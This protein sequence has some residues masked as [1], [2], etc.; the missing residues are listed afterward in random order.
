LDIKPEGKI[1]N[2][3]DLE[4]ILSALKADNKK[5]V[6]C[7]GVFDLVH[8][9]HIRYFNLAKKE[10]DILVVTLTSDKYVKRGPGRPIFN[11]NLRAEMLASI[12]IIDYVAIIDFPASIEAIKILKPNF[13]VKGSDYKDE[14][15]DV[16]GM[17][18]YE[19]EAVSS[20]G[21]KL[22]FT[23][24]ITFSS[25][26]LINNFLD[27][28]PQEI[29][30]YLKK[31]KE[32]Y[33]I[34]D[35]FDKINS[36]KKLKVLVIGDSIIDQY[37]YCTPLGKSSKEHLVANL[38]DSEETFAGGSL[39]TA[40]HIS[41]ICQKVDLLTVLGGKN[42]YKDFISEKLNSNIDL[43]YFIWPDTGTVVKRRFV[44]KAINTK[45]F[46]I[47]YLKREDIPEIVEEKILNHLDRTIKNYDLIVANDFG[48]G[49]LTKN[50]INLICEKSSYL[51]L[52]VQT[53]SANIG[54][55]MVTKYPRANFVCIDDLELRLATHDRVSDLKILAKEIFNLLNCDYIIATRGSYGSIGYST[56]EG[57]NE[58]PAFS[59][60][61]VDAIGAG[62]AFFSY[63]SPCIAGGFNL[64][65]TSFIGNAAGSLATQIICNREPV[66]YA[67]LMK[68]IT[69]LLK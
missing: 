7:H 29:S 2:L 47:C 13:Y 31:I 5:I 24:D 40:N 16:T 15:K 27:V 63:V 49:L 6:H 25:S 11:E 36:L 65:L 8:L 37:H 34:D 19:E 53:N 60:K 1:K 4:Q 32:K 33:S 44:S 9:G 46:E 17:I 66:R 55:N 56:D 50:I 14:S 26:S 22:I 58:C 20:V 67:D 42:S 54:F 23:D 38:Y 3:G 10:G 30:L 51:A 41:N 62:D 68:F 52:N 18:N 57:F 12:S 43:L 61:V 48:H 21:G 28:Y 64:D 39:A 59:Y 35:I 45:L 69:R